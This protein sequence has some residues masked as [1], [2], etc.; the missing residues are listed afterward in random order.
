MTEMPSFSASRGEFIFTGRLSIEITPA[1]GLCAPARMRMRVDLP[2]P[3]SPMRAC[4]SPGNRSKPTFCRAR[5][6]GKDLSMPF[7]WSRAVFEAASIGLFLGRRR[8]PDGFE[9]M[10]LQGEQFCGPASGEGFDESVGRRREEATGDGNAAVVAEDLQRGAID[11]DLQL[12]P[13]IF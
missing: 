5:T 3:F 10:N 1:S 8:G 13:A 2:A 4:T 7:I 11:E 6:P 9:L 12:E